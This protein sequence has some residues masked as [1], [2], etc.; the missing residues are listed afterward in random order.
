MHKSGNFRENIFTLFQYIVLWQ[1]L[2]CQDNPNDWK[3]VLIRQVFW[4]SKF[5]TQSYVVCRTY[6]VFTSCPLIAG[7]WHYRFI[8]FLI[9]T[10]WADTCLQGCFTHVTIRVHKWILKIKSGLM[11]RW[12]W[13]TKF[14]LPYMDNYYLVYQQ[15]WSFGLISPFV[16]QQNSN[17]TSFWP[18]YLCHFHDV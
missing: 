6:H 9:R 1:N 12:K 17:Y 16:Y 2:W 7:A 10:Y 13:L 3:L 5:Y 15:Q 18:K 8:V 14:S 4:H 11:S